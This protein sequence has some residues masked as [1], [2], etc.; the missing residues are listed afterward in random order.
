MAKASSMTRNNVEKKFSY[1]KILFLSRMHCI[2][3]S[4]SGSSKHS[5]YGKNLQLRLYD[6]YINTNINQLLTKMMQIT[7]RSRAVRLLTN[8]TVNISQREIAQPK[9]ANQM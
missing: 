5:D 8:C 3:M 7:M 2:L 6:K 9:M 1:M 4:D